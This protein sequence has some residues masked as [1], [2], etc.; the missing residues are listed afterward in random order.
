MINIVNFDIYKSNGKSYGGHSGMKNGITINGE[1][2][3]LKYPKSTKSMKVENLSYTT[4]P[5]SEYI[6]SNIYKSIGLLTHDTMLG[7]SS[8]KIA[9]ACKDFLSDTETIIDFNAIKNKYEPNSKEI[10]E[11][12]SSNFD[13]SDNLEDI[14]ELMKDNYYFKQVPELK[15]RFWDMFIIDALISNNDRN[16][17]NWGVI[18]DNATSNLRLAP[19]YDNGASFYSKSSDEKLESILKNEDKFYQVVYESSI[20]IFKLND[21]ILNPL[22]LIESKSIKECNDALLRIYPKI[23]LEKIKTIFDEIPL[24]LCSNIQKTFYFKVLDYRVNNILKPVYNELCI[25]NNK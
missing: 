6:G 13:K 12:H 8:N 7:I 4:S 19:V 9:V 23:N 10:E 14:M 21:K 18:Y 25:K 17:A 3:F 20:S 2:W 22:K 1:K 15:D 24:E 16:E 5:L 11:R